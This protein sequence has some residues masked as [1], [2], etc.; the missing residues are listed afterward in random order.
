MVQH[1]HRLIY[2]FTLSTEEEEP[3]DEDES[4]KIK[5]KSKRN[6]SIYLSL[7][8]WQQST[9]SAM[10]KSAEEH[11]YPLTKERPTRIDLGSGKLIKDGRERTVG[12]WSMGC[13]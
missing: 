3:F 12:D 11:L 7:D 6:G 4:V 8:E 2:Y 13:E 9:Y 1:D 10:G 5:S